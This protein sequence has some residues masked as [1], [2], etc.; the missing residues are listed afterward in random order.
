[1]TYLVATGDFQT[2]LDV[3]LDDRFPIIEVKD[4]RFPYYRGDAIN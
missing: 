1:M 4:D 3:H 2:A